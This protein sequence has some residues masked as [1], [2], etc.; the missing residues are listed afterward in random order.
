MN[1]ES[2][3]V[4]SGGVVRGSSLD[5]AFGRRLIHR[6]VPAHMLSRFYVWRESGG[7]PVAV[8][9][10]SRQWTGGDSPG[11]NIWVE[12]EHSSRRCRIGAQLVSVAEEHAAELGARAVYATHALE[13]QS[14]SLAAA[15]A[16]GYTQ[17]ESAIEWE[18]D[19]GLVYT[20]CDRLVHRICRRKRELEGLFMTEPAASWAQSTQHS[21]A[22]L[23]A[24]M[25]G[26]DTRDIVRRLKA[27]AVDRFDPQVSMAVL[28][29]S[30]L[31]AAAAL[32]SVGQRAGA[33]HAIV[34]GLFTVPKYRNSLATPMLKRA[35]AAAYAK[36]GGTVFTMSTMD[37]HAHTRRLAERLGP[38]SRRRMVRPYKLLA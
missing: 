13:D 38:V 4:P 10:M 23:H 2:L 1:T 19:A 5:H 20:E 9:A 14:P 30:G 21:V 34:E 6:R 17:S 31:V 12:V 24:Q 37:H 36:I 15:R 3:S 33:A 18:L 8:V 29:K 22:R 35:M 28:A 16:L 25:L 7:Q 27:S 26:G 11:P 32:V